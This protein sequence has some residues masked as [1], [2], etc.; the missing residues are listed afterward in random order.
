MAAR[1][2]G[3]VTHVRTASNVTLFDDSPKGGMNP[4]ARLGLTMWKI[5]Q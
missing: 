5:G 1:V 4:E 2:G 3:M